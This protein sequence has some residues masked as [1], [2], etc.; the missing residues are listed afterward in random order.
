MPP[1]DPI[2]ERTLQDVVEEL[3]LYPAEAF[4]FVQRGLGCTVAKLYGP[5]PT[6]REHQHISGRQLCDGL[7]EFALAQWGYL[8]GTVLRRWNIQSTMDFGR[9]V[10]ALVESGL[11][12]A[13]DDDSIDDFKNVYDFKTAFEGEYR[14]ESNP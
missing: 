1:K 7:R 5:N 14:I 10:F 13:T 11:M 9:I 12:Q 8:A 3:N 2:K 4:D 6:P